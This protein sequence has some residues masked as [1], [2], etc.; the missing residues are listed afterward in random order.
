MGNVQRPTAYHGVGV[1]DS[2]IGSL[3]LGGR[4][5]LLR[6]EIYGGCLS[7]PGR[8][9]KATL[10][11]NRKGVICYIASPEEMPIDSKGRR[12]DFI[13]DAGSSLSRMNLGRDFEP[14][15]NAAAEDDRDRIIEMLGINPKENQLSLQL[16][17][18][19]MEQRQDPRMLSAWAHALEFL[20]V[21]SPMS[22]SPI[23]NSPTYPGS[24]AGY[25]QSIIK[26]GFQLW[27]PTDAQ[28]DYVEA[29]AA[30]EEMPNHRPHYDVVHYRGYSGRLTK[31]KNRFRISRQT[32]IILEK[33]GD[34]WMAV[35]SG[36]RQHFGIPAP[37]TNL[38]KYHKPTRVNF[39]KNLGETEK[40]ILDAY[41]GPDAT[42][43][44][45]D[46]SNNPDTAKLVVEG[47]I[48]AAIP[49]NIPL[50]VDRNIYPYGGSKPLMLVK[51]ML[52]CSGTRYQY[53]P[54]RDPRAVEH[55]A[56]YRPTPLT[57]VV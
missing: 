29:V 21:V 17:L 55:M 40:R 57:P 51:H 23:F 54:Y 27:F 25:L 50:L 7:T 53:A 13:V 31:T 12:A 22:M 42:A 11:D 48:R 37:I 38:T 45:A 24:K 16:T 14:Y 2:E 34:D 6:I 1:S 56:N 49:T 36:P 39:V 3:P 15:F 41:I 19:E 10:L 20:Q 28:T 5:G 43:D 9:S 32:M 33:I 52:S 47:I 35:A 44:L 18:E 26:D 46:R 4:Y 30:L 8:E